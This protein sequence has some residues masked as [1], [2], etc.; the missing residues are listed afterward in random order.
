MEGNDSMKKTDNEK[1][2]VAVVEAA[3]VFPVMFIVI[4]VMIM[5]GEVFYQRARVQQEVMNIAIE[6]A[7]SCQNPMLEYVQ[8][9]GKVP[10]GTKDT[11]VMPYRYIFTGNMKSICQN[12]EE[13]LKEKINGYTALAFHGTKPKVKKISVKAENYF[14]VSYV[15][16]VCDYEIELPIR[17]LFEK[18]NFKFSYSTNVQQPVGDASEM[19]RNVL[20]VENLMQK[21]EAIMDACA[22]MSEKMKKLSQYLN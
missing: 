13:D 21:N 7:A 18:D 6:T 2:A 17:M 16:I 14:F 8:E 11:H 10:A 3:F 22:K 5:V 15:H 4:L 19:V 9:N 12:A 1:G 20:L